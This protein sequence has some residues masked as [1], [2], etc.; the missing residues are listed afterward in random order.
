MNGKSHAIGSGLAIALAAYYEATE[1]QAKSPGEASGRALM[2]GGLGAMC[3]S[4]PDLIE[5]ATS[6]HHRQFFHSLAF[7]LMAFEGLRRVYRW[8]PEDDLNRAIRG[9]TLIAGGAYLIHLAMDST[10]PMSLPLVGRI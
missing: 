3:G 1:F 2:A 9:L 5:P 7:G 4:L 10:T 6:P 8:H